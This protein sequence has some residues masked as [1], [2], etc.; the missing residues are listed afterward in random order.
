MRINEQFYDTHMSVGQGCAYRAR[1]NRV[2]RDCYGKG[3]AREI[4]EGYDRIDKKWLNLHYRTAIALVF[5]SIVVEG[6]FCC[7]LSRA[8]V[9]STSTTIFFIKYWI[10]PGAVNLLCV[11]IQTVIMRAKRLTQSVKIYIISLTFVMICFVLFTVHVIFAVLYFI[12]V[13]PV[14]LTVVYAN[15]RL[16]T[17]T[18]VFCLASVFVSELFIMWDPLKVSILDNTLRMMEFRIGMF[19]LL[20]FYGV[21]MV[22]ILFERQKNAD[23]I[24]GEIERK[25]LIRKLRMDELTGVCNRS[26]LHG[27]FAQMQR[28]PDK[29]YIFVIMDMDNFKTIN[30]T[31]GH[32]VGD[33]YLA[34]LG[35]I[36]T[37]NC[38]VGVPFRYGGDE[39]S[40]LFEDCRMKKV[41][42]ICRQIQKDLRM[43]SREKQ[44][45]FILTV[46]MGIAAHRKGMDCHTLVSNA[47]K[48]LYQAK[49]ARNAIHI[50]RADAG[51]DGVRG[52]AFA[53]S[54]Y[55]THE[56]SLDFH[57]M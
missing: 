43:M 53:D 55:K 4:Q 24:L 12:F 2:G 13:F 5:I 42:R 47:D 11:L 1:I 44:M 57:K 48:A 8:A 31:R 17:V 35:K 25:L 41:V 40:I 21:C 39:F 36:L 28:Y 30:D 10:A 51:E 46:S 52:G 38:V 20:S 9:V 14:V 16:T 49:A 32:V 34:G 50:Y 6:I 54:V 29:R 26:A 45:D 18:A 15:Y 19:S 23:V 3:L 27:A 56:D 37:K 7:I 22:V 33:R